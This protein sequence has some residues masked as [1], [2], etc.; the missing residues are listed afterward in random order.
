MINARP[1]DGRLTDMGAVQLMS[2]SKL[3]HH[4]KWVT[5]KLALRLPAVARRRGAACRRARD[6]QLR[7][8]AARAR[9]RNHPRGLMTVSYAHGT[10]DVPLLGETIGANLRR[11]VERFGEREALVV[12]H[13]HYRATYRELWL[14]VDCA[15]RALIARGVRKGDRVG[16]WAP[17]RY[18]WVVTQFAT[19]RVG[20]I[21]VTVN[22]AYKAAEL[23]HA[24]G[25]AG[26]SLL[27]M[28][29]GFR[30]AD[31]VAMLAES[32]S[33][34]RCATRSCSKT[35]GSRSSP[36]ARAS[37]TPSWP[38]ARRRFSFDDP[39]N[40]QY[41]SGTTGRAQGRDPDAPQHP[42]QRLLHR[43]RAGA[44]AS[45]TGVRPGALLPHLRHGPRHA[46][47]CAGHGAC[48]VVPERVVRRGR[49]ARGG[50]RG[51]LHLALRRADDV[52]R[53][54][55]ASALR[56]VRS[57]QPADRHDGRRAVPGR[58]DEAGPVADAHG[59]GRRSSA[60]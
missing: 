58:A 44:T 33:A 23:A 36:T 13:Q 28:A 34:S 49:G 47:R 5:A 6:R 38:R 3:S 14:E 45:A 41:T 12:A 11:T 8:A 7:A 35:T 46:S 43:A 60:A 55:R 24:L 29:R 15:A 16:I 48:M 59:A 17:N 19:A 22:P 21:L 30:V 52:H 51:A 39:I 37:P 26:V 1:A 53:R 20:A 31:Y 54:A 9:R 42:Q 18:E 2:G 32:A 57:L 56:A 25:K 4:G 10:S 50:R 40:I 27:V